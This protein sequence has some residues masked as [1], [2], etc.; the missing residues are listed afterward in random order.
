MHVTN[1]ST[2][3]ITHLLLKQKALTVAEGAINFIFENIPR[4]VSIPI[5]SALKLKNRGEAVAIN[6]VAL[7]PMSRGAARAKINNAA[8]G[9]QHARPK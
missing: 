1:K 4:W 3:I 6:W 5:Q 7:K 8:R 2:A 9:R